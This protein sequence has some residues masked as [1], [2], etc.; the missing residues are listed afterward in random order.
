MSQTVGNAAPDGATALDLTV[1]P[2]GACLGAEIRG[3]DLRRI[4]DRDFAAIHRAWLDHLVLL[5]RDQRLSDDEL[6]AFSR[7]LGELD[8]APVQETGRR[9]VE[10]H[11]ELYV[12]S[13]VVENGIPIGSL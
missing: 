13:N 4:D 5:F 6:I 1:V 11:P 7:R 3:V 2:S 8:W 10:G 12:V 9:F